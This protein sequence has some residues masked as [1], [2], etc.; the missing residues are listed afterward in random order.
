VSALFLSTSSLRWASLVPLL[1][2]SLAVMGSPGPATISLTASGVAYGVRRTARYLAGIIPGTLIV[3][4]AVAAGLPGALLAVPGLRP[5]LLAVS[6]A[7]VLYLAFH[8]ATAPPLRAARRAAR[9][10]RRAVAAR[11][12]P[13]VRAPAPDRP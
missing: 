10:G 12:R 9:P 7:Y 3:L 2:T 5:V 13:G 4:L 8:I 1:L 6:I 11:R